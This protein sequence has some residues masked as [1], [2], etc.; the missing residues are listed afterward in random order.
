MNSE[1]VEIESTEQKL[2]K[3]KPKHNQVG[4]QAEGS[5]KTQI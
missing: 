2:I 4:R 1:N 3:Q 5:L